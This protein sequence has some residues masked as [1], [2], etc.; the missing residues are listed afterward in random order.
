VPQVVV[1]VEIFVAQCQGIHALTDQLQ[2]RVLDQLRVAV[3]VKASGK[4]PQDAHLLLDFS[5][6]Q[7]A[8]IGGDPSTVEPSYHIALAKAVKRKRL[9]ST[10]CRH[11]A[12]SSLST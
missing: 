5:Q 10:L 2:H 8:R 11:R 3:I 6:Q 1:I 9:L 7:P 12:V 4:S